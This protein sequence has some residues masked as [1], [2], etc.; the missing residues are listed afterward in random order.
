MELQGL[1]EAGLR[2]SLQRAQ[3]ARFGNIATEACLQ[4]GLQGDFPLLALY[5]LVKSGEIYVAGADSPI[6]RQLGI[7]D[8][9]FCLIPGQP[10]LT[11]VRAFMRR[12][13]ATGHALFKFNA[14]C[15]AGRYGFKRT[16]T[17]EM[18]A[19]CQRFR[20]QL[21]NHFDEYQANSL[22]A[23]LVAVMLIEGMENFD[24]LRAEELETKA[25]ELHSKPET[26]LSFF[27]K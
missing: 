16:V 23:S 9:G 13:A 19:R 27:E 15:A 17:S 5:A 7:D 1:S 11:E 12:Q 26:I 18:V 4:F 20:G 8:E 21:K 25:Q 14:L 6:P 22:R 2:L 10:I 3:F 24:P